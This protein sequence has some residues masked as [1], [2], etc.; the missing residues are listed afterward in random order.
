LIIIVFTIIINVI[1]NNDLSG[2]LRQA[3]SQ[4]KYKLLSSK[5]FF[6]LLKL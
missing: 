3:A 6:E 5:Y 4:Q 1:Q 2:I